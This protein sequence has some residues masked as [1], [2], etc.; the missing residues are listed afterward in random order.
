MHSLDELR[1]E[2]NNQIKINL[3]V[4]DLSSDA[5]MIPINE[6]ARKISFDKIIKKHF[7]TDDSASF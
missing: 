2:S 6:F 5:G 1:L 3:N 4:G 7:K